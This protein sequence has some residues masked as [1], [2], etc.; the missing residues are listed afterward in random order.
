LSIGKR[1]DF[2]QTIFY[3]KTQPNQLFYK[4]P[5]YILFDLFA[6][7][8]T[9]VNVLDNHSLL[10][11]LLQIIHAT[12]DQPQ[13]LQQII[14]EDGSFINGSFQLDKIRKKLNLIPIAP[15]LISSILTTELKNILEEYNQK[16][17]HTTALAYYWASK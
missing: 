3:T 7:K 10:M 5:L 16:R 14:E 13:L 8:A 6:V 15:N 1:C 4:N 2:S 12:K 11:N 17:D 9:Q